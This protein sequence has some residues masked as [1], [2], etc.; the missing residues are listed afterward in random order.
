MK[1]APNKNKNTLF[2]YTKRTHL[3]GLQTASSQHE[4]NSNHL[5]ATRMNEKGC[6]L[7]DSICAR[8]NM[9]M[10]ELATC[11]WNQSKY[12]CKCT[13]TNRPSRT[14]G[15]GVSDLTLREFVITVLRM[16][17]RCSFSLF[18]FGPFSLP[19]WFLSR[20]PC[21]LCTACGPCVC[22]WLLPQSFSCRPFAIQSKVQLS[23]CRKHFV[24]VASAHVI[25]IYLC[26]FL[27]SGSY[28]VLSSIPSLDVL[29]CLHVFS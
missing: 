18:S 25:F 9:Q 16:W 15:E 11:S 29:L 13:T 7:R 6:T 17:S 24:L 23:P 12:A 10:K 8:I 19:V 28:T 26:I 3:I 21:S 2:L 14:R 4:N 22:V 20:L 5:Q 27:A 1:R